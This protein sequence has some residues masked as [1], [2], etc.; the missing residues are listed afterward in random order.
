MQT[1]KL[2]YEDSHLKT[3]R[4]QVLSY[5]PEKDYFVVTLDATAFYPEGG[6]QAGDTGVLGG[7]RVLDTHERGETVAHYC[8][9]PLEPGQTVEGTI[10]WE[11]RFRRMQQHSGEHIV[12]GMLCARFAC[13]NVGFHMGEDLVTIDYNADIPWDALLAV[14]AAANRY[15]WEDHPVDIRLHRGEELAAI[16]YRS[17]KAIPGDVRI[18]TFPGADC[19]ACCGTHVKTSAEVGLVKFLSVQKFRQGVRIELLC[20]GRAQRYL[21]RC[22]E[23]AR[24]T[25]QAL[26]VKPEASYPAVEK[27]LSELSARKADAAQWQTLAFQGIARSV[28]GKGDVLLLQPPMEGTALRRLADAAAEQCGGLAAVFAGEDGRWSYALCRHGGDVSA[29]T[30]A[31]NAALSGR[32]GGRG[33]L[34]QGSVQ[35]AKAQ[36]ETYFSTFTKG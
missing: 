13:D 5:Q 9:A 27:L 12:S 21:S 29:E 25:G 7:V 26:S 22:W 1:R 10:D 30:K 8:A 4:A 35:A 32:G 16:D 24:A 20:G 19:C 28:A 2:Y 23:Q 34:S 6:G 31:M 15:L 36:I 18:V 11:A 17:K 14:E 33:P 3:F